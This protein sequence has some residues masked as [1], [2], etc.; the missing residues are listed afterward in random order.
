MRSDKIE[1]MGVV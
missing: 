1:E